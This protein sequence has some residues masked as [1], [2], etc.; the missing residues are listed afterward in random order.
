MEWERREQT[1]LFPERPRPSHAADGVKMQVHGQFEKPDQVILSVDCS[2]FRVCAR[3]FICL[4]VRVYKGIMFG[5]QPSPLASYQCFWDVITGLLLQECSRVILLVKLVRT[6][7]H[8]SG[9]RC[10]QPMAFSTLFSK[11][12]S[13]RCWMLCEI[14]QRSLRDRSPWSYLYDP[15]SGAH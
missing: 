14:A 9:R 3:N 13:S 8:M 11:F 15:R 7:V 10:A 1:L 5:W 6:Q 2:V 4:L 12:V